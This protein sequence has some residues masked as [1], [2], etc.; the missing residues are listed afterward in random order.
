MDFFKMN[1]EP[2]SMSLI[3]NQKILMSLVESSGSLG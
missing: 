3:R 2:V 1:R